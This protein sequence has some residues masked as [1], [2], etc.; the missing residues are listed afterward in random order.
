MNEVLSDCSFVIIPSAP[1]CV[2]RGAQVSVLGLSV[3]GLGV[4]GQNPRRGSIQFLLSLGDA[5]GHGS[6]H[7]K[8]S[9]HRIGVSEVLNE[10][11]RSSL[12]LGNTAGH[13]Q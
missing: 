13:K 6:E 11:F 9:R 12:V 10:Y 2:T 5:F 8:A 3:L 1:M 4:Y 7:S